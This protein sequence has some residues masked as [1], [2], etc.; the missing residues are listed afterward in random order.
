MG[1]A[2]EEGTVLRGSACASGVEEEEGRMCVCKRVPPISIRQGATRNDKDFL[3]RSIPVSIVDISF[4]CVYKWGIIK[5]SK[6]VPFAQGRL[7]F[8]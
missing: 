5:R 7:W 3:D 2:R 8:T 1:T 6:M 4:I